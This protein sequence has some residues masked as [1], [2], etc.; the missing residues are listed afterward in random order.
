MF[1]TLAGGARV[2]K[3]ETARFG[4]CVEDRVGHHPIFTRP[5]ELTFLEIDPP[6]ADALRAG[7]G[8]VGPVVTP[9]RPVAHE[10]R[11]AGDTQQLFGFELQPV[12]QSTGA[13]QTRGGHVLDGGLGHGTRRSQ[14]GNRCPRPVDEEVE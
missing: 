5:V 12:G 14:I 13:M 11:G 1:P 4:D 2:R 3:G 10:R 8:D 7:H 6:V 9:F